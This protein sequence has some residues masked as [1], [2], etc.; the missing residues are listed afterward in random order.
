MLR[1]TS[2]L[3]PLLRQHPR[4]TRPLMSSQSSSP[5]AGLAVNVFDFLNE[6]PRDPR[7]P[8]IAGTPEP[9]MRVPRSVPRAAYSLVV[10]E[11]PPEPELECVSPS[12]LALLGIAPPKPHDFL[13]RSWSETDRNQLVSYL[14]GTALPDGAI[15]WAHNYAGHQFGVF[16]GQLG[17]GRAISIGQIRPSGTEATDDYESAGVQELQLKGA[18]NTPYSRMGDGFAVLRSSIRE[19]LCSEHFAALGIPTTRAASLIRTGQPV[20]REELE[21]GAIVARLAPTWIRFGS[22]ESFAF[23]GDVVNS[24]KLAQYVVRHIYPESLINNPTSTTS[25]TTTTTSRMFRSVV[26]RTARTVA[27]WDLVAWQHGVLNTDNMSIAGYTLDFGPFGFL[28]HWDPDFILNHSDSAGRYSVRNQRIIG[29]YNLSKLANALVEVVGWETS[30]KSLAEI[31]GLTDDQVADID[32]RQ[33]M[34]DRGKAPLVKELERYN[35]L[36][37]EAYTSGMRKKLGLATAHPDDQKLIIDPLLHVLELGQADWTR[38]FRHLSHLDPYSSLIPSDSESDPIVE[39]LVL[40]A[41]ES[42]TAC[43]MPPTVTDN[44]YVSAAVSAAAAPDTPAASKPVGTV[45]EVRTAYRAWRTAYLTRAQQETGTGSA[46]ARVAAM[47]A[48]NPKFILRQ[49]IAQETIDA[50]EK[51][52]DREAVARALCVLTD[53]FAETPAGVEAFTEGV[54]KGWWEKWADEPPAWGKGIVCSCSS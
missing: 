44:N 16:A 42:A 41:A 17:D 10:P 54:E 7:T 12:A 6:L 48:T 8:S 49:W 34:A 11:T 18:G 36:Y 24:A 46:A 26:Q 4:P 32:A 47:H 28:D 27:A 45:D 25:S 39:P 50:S 15:P 9:A 20:H 52:G 53:P 2:R 3:L 38:F 14:S 23:R 33:E 21:P 40:A 31:A 1:A 19:F 5:L 13:L 43:A 35:D 51:R 37:W 29:M 22:F 30:G